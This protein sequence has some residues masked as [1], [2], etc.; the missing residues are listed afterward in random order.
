MSVVSQACFGFLKPSFNFLC[1]KNNKK[2]ENRQEKF[3]QKRFFLT[4]QKRI[5]A[6]E[7]RL[8]KFTDE[9]KKAM[10]SYLNKN[11]PTAQET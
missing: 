2:K 6:N 8:A 1:N 5:K 10:A 11:S 3:F 9:Q 4:R 7:A